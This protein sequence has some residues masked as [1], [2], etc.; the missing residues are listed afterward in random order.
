MLIKSSKKKD[1]EDFDQ[2]GEPSHLDDYDYGMYGKV[3]EY[4]DESGGSGDDVS[5]YASFG[6]LLMRL[7]G[8]KEVLKYIHLDDNIYVFLRV[9]RTQKY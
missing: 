3:F 7:K 6:G 2:S 4:V 5:I 8:P 1:P 9:V